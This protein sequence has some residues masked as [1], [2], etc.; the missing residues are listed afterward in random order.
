M[1]GKTESMKLFVI[2]WSLVL[3][4]SGGVLAQQSQPLWPEGKVPY[5]KPIDAETGSPLLTLYP[6]KSHSNHN[7]AAVVICPGGGYG[8]LAVDHE[9]NQPARWFQEQGVS[10][11]VLQYR[12][13]SQGHHYPTQLADVQ[14]A[15]RWVRSHAKDYDLD[16]GRIA[17]M[18]FSAGGHLASM[19]A[20]LYDEMAYDSSD[21]VDGVS[22][23]PDF[24]ILC[25][26]VISMDAEVTHGGSRKNLL[27]ADRVDDDVLAEKLSSE[28]NVTSETPRTFIF[29]TNADTSVRAENAVGFYLALRQKEVPAEMHIYQEG[30]HG[31]GLYRGDPVLGTWSGLLQHWLRTNFFF[32]PEPMRAAVKGEV[33]LDGNPV[34]WGVLSFYPDDSNLPVTSVRIRRG[35]YSAN[36]AQGPVV[37]NARISFE[38]S[39]WEATGDANDQAVKLQSLTPSDENPIEVTIESVGKP[40]GKPVG[41]PMNF[42][43]RSR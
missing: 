5:E 12:L 27:G 28:K 15:I 1:V 41:K 21:S 30:P 13:G 36:E 11:F 9:G 20:T 33:T 18:G 16:P 14:R 2:V 19:A 42:E 8:G 22:A 39:I 32:A 23:R 38:G 43:F 7:G 17:V 26:P 25:Y 34:S 4:I 37:G 35:K 31:V 24:A 6:T 3:G 40:G 10:A 29:Q